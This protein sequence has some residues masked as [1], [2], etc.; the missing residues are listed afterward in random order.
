MNSRDLKM[1]T[2]IA[3]VYNEESGIEIFISSS[4]AVLDSL[5]IENAVSTE[6]LLVNDGSTDATKHQIERLIESRRS[7]SKPTSLKLI[8]LSRNFGH[9]VAVWAGIESAFVESFVIVMDSDMQDDPGLIKNIFD[10][11]LKGEEVVLMQ[12]STRQDTFTKKLFA[13]IFYRVLSRVSDVELARNTGDFYGLSPRAKKALL[14]HKESVKFLRG[15]VQSI[16]FKK[17]ILTYDRSA[18]YSGST[19]YTMSK[20]IKLAISGITGFSV[21]PLIYIAYLAIF[22]LIFDFLL[23]ITVTYLHF[24]NVYVFPPGWTFMMFA[25]LLLSAI[26]IFCFAVISIYLARVTLEIKR[27]PVY[28]VAEEIQ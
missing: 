25:T 21:N 18:R 6:L 23:V 24:S 9:Q 8:S 19:H 10:E 1:L 17:K 3:P 15:L 7:D 16:G 22:S 12:R 14:M 2:V 5:S 26:Q 27:R 20:M 11:F 28:F 4:L 13:S